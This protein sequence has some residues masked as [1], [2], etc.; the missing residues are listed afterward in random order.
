M[1][2]GSWMV[3]FMFLFGGLLVAQGAAAASGDT[4]T[5]S[6]DGQWNMAVTLLPFT[7]DQGVVSSN[8]NVGKTFHAEVVVLKETCSAPGQ[9][10][11]TMHN[12]PGQG[13]TGA[14]SGYADPT[15][16]LDGPPDPGLTRHG[17]ALTGTLPNSNN[18][19][20]AIPC[21][22]PPGPLATLT[23]HVTTAV[24][25]P[26]GSHAVTITGHEDS[27]DNYCG[28]I[29]KT[30]TLS[31]PG[32][33]HLSIV[34]HPV[35][36]VASKAATQSKTATRSSSAPQSGL[37]TTIPADTLAHPQPSSI[38]STI[39]TPAQ[40]FGSI[41]S[42]ALG[43]VITMAAVLLITFPAQIFNKTFEENYDEIR[44]IAIRRFGWLAKWRT[45]DR[46]KSHRE[47]RTLVFLLTLLAGAILGGLLDPQFGFNS[48]SVPTFASTLLAIAF[49]IGAST[50]AAAIYRRARHRGL[51]FSPQAI[52]AGLAIAAGCVLVS[53]LIAF[54]PGYL[55]GVIA[56]LA[57]T[58]EL[59]DKENAHVVVVATAV[60]L[61]SAMVAWAIWV[62][63]HISAA[64]RGAGFGIVLLDDFVGAVFVSGLV[65]SVISLVPLNLLPGGTLIAW[66]RKAWIITFGI[67][68]FGLV[69]VMMRPEYRSTHSSRASWVV[70]ILL[71]TAFG[72]GS[73]AFRAYFNRRQTLKVE[74]GAGPAGDPPGSPEPTSI[75]STGS[76]STPPVREGDPA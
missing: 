64:H 40:A 37:S 17:S 27:L 72:A 32:Y 75:L 19:S 35:G 8:V 74:E 69:Q 43:I 65:G 71:F 61:A 33:Y 13:S 76:E 22:P 30:S 14:Q 48:R 3:A 31:N 67:A 54:E 66:N 28:S 46:A 41:G 25:G 42:V 58:S 7:G 20:S 29:N 52:P 49:G 2:M 10:T 11:V 9:C 47:R 62:P 70:V 55:Y 26:H 39:S 6:V 16:A 45:R 34:G 21:P 44:D 60:I 12:L 73:I 51:K 38:T 24:A 56:G 57:F 1:R 15:S 18:V 5:A 53:R 50:G 36:F 59:E 23:F 4:R 68:V 63:V